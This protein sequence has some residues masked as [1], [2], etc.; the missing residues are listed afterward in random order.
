[1]RLTAALRSQTSPSPPGSRPRPQLRATAQVGS[2]PAPI[3]GWNR[4]DVLSAMAP[5][6]A[7][8]LENWI[9]DTGAVQLRN[10]YSSWGTGLTGN[11]VESLMQYSPPSGSNKLFAATPTII[12][13]VTTAGAG[14]SSQ[15][16]LTNGRWSDAMF[17]TSA[18]NFMYIANGADTP[19]YYDGAAWTNTAF[20]G[21]TVTNLDFVHSHLNRLWFIEKDTLNAWYGDTSAIAGALTQL[22]LGPFCKL[23]GK[24]VAIGSWT[25]DGGTGG[26]DDYLVFVTSKGQVIIY[27]GTDPS[28]FGSTVQVGVFKVAEPIGR[29]CLINLGSDMGVLTSQ[30]LQSLMQLL[31]Q[32]EGQAAASTITDKIVNAFRDAYQIAGTSFGWQVF[33][34]PKKNLLFV[35]VPVTERATQNQFVMN[36]RT[37]AWSKFSNINAGCWSLLGDVPYFGGNDGKVYKYGADFTDNGN[38]I[39]ATIQTAFTNFGAVGN[40]RFTMAR[41][42]FL[43]PSG[44]APRLSVKTDYDTSTA[45]LTVID[46]SGNGTAWD[47]G[48]WDVSVWGPAQVPSLPWQTI[49][50]IGVVGSLAF[51]ISSQ[52]NIAFNN[53]EVVFEAGGLL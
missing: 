43:S 28:V 35:N 5:T 18:G 24:L 14:S 21:P 33:E 39:V 51:S 31:P 7:I 30:G 50:G 20:T 2:I 26:A 12:Y 32:T 34:Y 11:Y 9:P 38:S 42:L 1:M 37:G 23:G 47:T 4:R 44:Y 6:D 53:A 15:T 45:G 13:N 27:A 36:T 3:G 8:A 40:K 19:R 49:N 46:T 25:R 16:G 17:T 10:G 48:L 29:R 52:S 41:G 22:I